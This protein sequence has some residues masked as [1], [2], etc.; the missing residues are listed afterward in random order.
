LLTKNFT[1][2]AAKI[3]CDILSESL[4]ISKLNITVITQ[5]KARGLK[6]GKKG[7]KGTAPFFEPLRNWG[8]PLI[9][10][11]NHGFKVS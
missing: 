2:K 3:H 6:K 11:D 7:K 1:L 8:Q 4:N 9:N 5:S 10:I